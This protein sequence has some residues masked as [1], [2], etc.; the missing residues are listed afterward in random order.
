MRHC[1]RWFTLFFG[2]VLCALFPGCSD[3]GSVALSTTGGEV[4]WVPQRQ[5]IA[6][7]TQ[8]L[9]AVAEWAATVR[10]AAMKSSY[11]NFVPSP[12]IKSE[13]WFLMRS[14]RELI[15]SYCHDSKGVSRQVCWDARHED[16]KIIQIIDSLGKQFSD[17]ST[18]FSEPPPSK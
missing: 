16:A 14:G 7:T 1:P 8:Q 5:A 11:V 2:C 17:S 12:G 3:R 15:L 13:S 9:A 4:F 18:H 6:L 10:P